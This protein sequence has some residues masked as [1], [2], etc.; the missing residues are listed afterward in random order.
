MSLECLPWSEEC[1]LP[2]S[3]LQNSTLTSATEPCEV[4]IDN[5]VLPEDLT[6][7][8]EDETVRRV[9]PGAYQHVEGISR[10]N[11]V[12]ARDDHGKG[13]AAAN[14]LEA[15]DH[16]AVKILAASPIDGTLHVG[17]GW[18]SH[19]EAGCRLFDIVEVQAQN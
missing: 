5:A 11:A 6:S 15:V 4:L 8:A 19:A 17:T 10:R 18:G 7:Q 16:E 1:S 12:A 2:P 14:A 9:E 3:V 13:R